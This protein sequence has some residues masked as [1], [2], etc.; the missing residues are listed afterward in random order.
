MYISSLNAGLLSTVIGRESLIRLSDPI[1]VKLYNKLSRLNALHVA[2]IYG[3]VSVLWIVFSDRILLQLVDSPDV[4]ARYQTVKGLVFVSLSTLLVYL[5]VKAS[6]N[7]LN[8]TLLEKEVLLSEI[9][10]RVKN[11]LAL[12]SSLIQLQAYQEEHKRTSDTLLKSVRRVGSIALVHE[13]VYQSESLANIPFDELVPGLVELV[14]QHFQLSEGNPSLQAEP[15]RL[16]VTQAVSCALFLNEALSYVCQQSNT[17]SREPTLRIVLTR[18][19]DSTVMEV[20]S[21]S[22]PGEFPAD[23]SDY[24]ILELELLELL[25]QQLDGT[26]RIHM[27]DGLHISVSFDGS[28]D[29]RGRAAH[30]NI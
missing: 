15:V 17:G 11:N 3:V 2:V 14:T 20:H 4:V 18:E 27:D 28:K 7:K 24:Q 23:P 16:N 30:H 19:E 13:H 21:D 25:S 5:L 6:H 22:P 9:H 8:E 26:L 10:H 1:K 29:F 12:I